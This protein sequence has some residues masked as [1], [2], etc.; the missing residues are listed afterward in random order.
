MTRAAPAAIALLLI[1]GA[2]L[3][4]SASAA[5]APNGEMRL[6]DVQEFDRT[7]FQITVYENG[8]ARW[9]FIYQ[10]TLENESQV[11]Q[12]EAYAQE[13]NNNET[14][15][16]RD[17]QRRAHNLAAGGTN[18]T[19]RE[20]EAT[21]FSREA[22][23]ND[24]NNQQGEVRM[25]FTWTN[26][27]A[28]D[29]NRLVI[30]DVFEGGLYVGPNQRL[31]VTTGPNLSIVE[32]RPAPDAT[33]TDS[34]TWNGEQ[35]FSDNRPEVVFAPAN[36]GSGTPIG[37]A[38]PTNTGTQAPPGGGGGDTGLLGLFALALVAILGVGVAFA[39][40]TGIFGGDD[41]GAGA[42][43][44]ADGGDDGG[45][46]ATEPAVTDEELLSDDRRVMNLLEEKGGRMKQVNI[47]EET[48]WSKSKVSML[49]SDMEEDEQI[50]KLR[51]GRENI[52]S[53]KGQEPEAAGSPFDDE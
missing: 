23:I 18:V 48:G 9:T 53:I 49:L 38:T 5:L 3:I 41:A 1:L 29:G 17:F 2:M 30:G 14:Q 13:F 20:M 10:K 24:F 11:Q 26:F 16:Y 43:A 52:I 42:A 40:R 33:S 19:G 15:L 28:E 35:S 12:F 34:L 50:S 36:S 25:S 45:A 6:N 22:S 31:V 46:A 7:E 27:A 47:V 32:G 4:P 8:S 39:Y 37:T 44:G 51:V 21:G